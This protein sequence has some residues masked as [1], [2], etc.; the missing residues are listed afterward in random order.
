[1]YDVCMMHK[2]LRSLI[3]M[4]LG[5]LPCA[6][7]VA[8]APIERSIKFCYKLSMGAAAAAG[9]DRGTIRLGF[10]DFNI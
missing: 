6:P 2:Y 10:E 3:L 4:H 1:M 9:A 5:V 8:A 7:A